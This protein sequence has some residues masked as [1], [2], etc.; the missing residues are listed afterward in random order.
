MRTEKI[1]SRDLSV[2][3]QG[4]LGKNPTVDGI[5]ACL[6][7]LHQWAPEA[8]IIIS[9]WPGQD[10]GRL[11]PYCIVIQPKDPGGWRDYLVTINPNR[12]LLSTQVGI[13]RATRPYVLK[14]RAD[15]RLTSD[16]FLQLGFYDDSA[17]NRL[18]DRPITVPTLF[19][20]NPAVCPMLFH[21]SDLIQLGTRTA[22]QKLWSPDLYT[23]E[24][25]MIAESD[26]PEIFGNLIGHT[27][28][29]NAPEQLYIKSL[30][31]NS[32]Q[33]IN[34]P[35][36][37]TLSP[38]LITLSERLLVNDFL[39]LEHHSCGVDFPPRFFDPRDMQATLYTVQQL[40]KIKTQ[41]GTPAYRWRIAY[42]YLNKYCFSLF[43]IRW[44]RSMAAKFIYT[45]LPHLAPKLRDVKRKLQGRA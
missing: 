24:E 45:Y 29:K 18:F 44:V 14:M 37:T 30:L 25:G 5:D 9:T 39:V 43:T 13:A 8:E 28:M 34:L 33:P 27:R 2:V 15:H 7:S 1:H 35:R 3:I 42:I 32:G 22:M 19:I 23:R 11:P 26:P 12:Q 20:R 10:V 4:P 17:S 6:A 16:A 21:V 38:A 36:T 40:H 41:L 31:A